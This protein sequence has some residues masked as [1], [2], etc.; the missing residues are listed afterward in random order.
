MRG[1]QS[2]C[3]G[4][5]FGDLVDDDD[6]RRGCQDGGRQELEERMIRDF[7]AHQ[8]D[9]FRRALTRAWHALS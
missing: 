8:A 1:A 4:E 3:R 5:P 7:S 9:Q 6:S 2:S